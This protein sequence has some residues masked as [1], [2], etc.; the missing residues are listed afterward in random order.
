MLFCLIE[1]VIQLNE[2]RL[3]SHD[4]RASTLLI[5]VLSCQLPEAFC[6]E[7]I[8]TPRT[9][10][11]QVL[12][13]P[14]FDYF[15]LACSHFRSLSVLFHLSLQHYQQK[16]RCGREYSFQRTYQN[17]KGIQL[18]IATANI[19]IFPLPSTL[20]QGNQY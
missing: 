18:S 17:T 14:T 12:A 13:T 16:H 8:R 3:N 20:E 9:N 1:V 11:L 6:F 2:F 4:N 15:Y 7:S 10:K 19:L 5:N